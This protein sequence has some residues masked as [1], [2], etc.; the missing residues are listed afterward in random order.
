MQNALW[1]K[2]KAETP[3]LV[4]D[5]GSHR[6]YCPQK[7]VSKSEKT[8]KKIWILKARRQFQTYQPGMVPYDQNLSFWE[9]QSYPQVLSKIEASLHYI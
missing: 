1:N 3:S 9:D 6:W 8:K 7:S 5:K 4:S 2:N